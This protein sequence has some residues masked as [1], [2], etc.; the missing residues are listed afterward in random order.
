MILSIIV[1]LYI[2]VKYVDRIINMCVKACNVAGITNNAEIIFI[3]DYPDE[4]VKIPCS[5]M[6][7]SVIENGHNMGIHRS[8]LIGLD[9]AS[10]EYIHFLDQ[11]DI[12]YEDFYKSL[13]QNI[14]NKDV[15]VSNGIIE[16]SKE[17]ENTK[18]IYQSKFHMSMVK[19]CLPYVLFDNRILS[20]GQCILKRNS[21]PDLWCKE[22]LSKNGADDFFLWILMLY[23]KKSFAIVDEVLYVHKNT[24]NNSSFD[25]LAMLGSLSEVVDILDKNFETVYTKILK[26]KVMHLN[27]ERTILCF[28]FDILMS[29]R[30][31]RIKQ[32]LKR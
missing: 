15:I 28:V 10:G 30:K 7:V 19:N 4:I 25:G 14:C 24:G 32:M 16:L 12:I 8:R 5:N 11:D 21:I 27:G 1:P 22:T 29:I 26:S 17:N 31:K 9:C 2:G 18:T 23:N 3:N 20:P 13:L 6:K